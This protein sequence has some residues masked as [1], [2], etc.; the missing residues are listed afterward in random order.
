MQIFAVFVFRRP[1]YQN[2]GAYRITQPARRTQLAV[3]NVAGVSFPG[4]LRSPGALRETMP[5]QQQRYGSDFLLC[6]LAHAVVS[7]EGFR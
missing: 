6:A 3:G 2:V 1:R 4:L 5:A 7:G